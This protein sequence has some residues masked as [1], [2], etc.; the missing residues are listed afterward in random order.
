MVP[1]GSP[2][3]VEKSDH[4][5]LFSLSAVNCTY[6]R[7]IALTPKNEP[8]RAN[9]RQ[10]RFVAVLKPPDFTDFADSIRPIRVVSGSFFFLPRLT[11]RFQLGSPQISTNSGVSFL[12][13]RVIGKIRGYNSY[14]GYAGTR[15]RGRPRSFV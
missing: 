11:T 8:P 15:G 1:L 5:R 2:S 14:E 9:E 13:I 3:L 12:P 4:L 6:C 7:L 10:G